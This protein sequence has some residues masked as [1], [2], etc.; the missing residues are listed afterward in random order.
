LRLPTRDKIP[1][2]KVYV[3]FLVSEDVYRMLVEM[4]PLIYGKGR[5]GMSRIVTHC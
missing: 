1:K 5:G 3:G 2:G 4:A